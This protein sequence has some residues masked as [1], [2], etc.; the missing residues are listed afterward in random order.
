MVEQ[1]GWIDLRSFRGE[2]QERSEDYE[3]ERGVWHRDWYV[4][5]GNQISKNESSL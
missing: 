3:A 4:S 5:L 1:V 2:Y